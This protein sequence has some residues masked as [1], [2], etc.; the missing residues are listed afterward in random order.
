MQGY[1]SDYYAVKQEA[2]QVVSLAIT[3]QHPSST[4]TRG[5][6]CWRRCSVAVSS[7]LCRRGGHPR[8]RWCAVLGTGNRPGMSWRGEEGAGDTVEGRGDDGERT[9]HDECCG[10]EGR[11]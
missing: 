5:I 2:T 6:C 11:R 7:R 1:F 4:D 9:R 8:L 3:N 10:I